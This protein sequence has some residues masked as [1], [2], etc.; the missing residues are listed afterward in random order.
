MSSG[1]VVSVNV[2]RRVPRRRPDVPSTAI[3]KQP[4]GRIDVRDPGPK[5]GGLGSGAVGDEIGDP[6]HHGGRLQAVY[7]YAVEDQRWWAMQLGRPIAPGG[8]GENLTLEG[9]EM[10]RALVGEL[11]TVGGAVLRVEVPRIPCGTFAEHMDV[12]Q[13]VR[14]FTDEGRTGAYLSVVTPGTIEADAPVHVEQPDHDI[15]LLVLVRA[16]TGDLD[17]MRRVIDARVIDA[18]V[19]TDLEHTLARRGG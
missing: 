1:R 16:F 10:T 9:V 6:R 7:A 3:D 15:D 13:W 18:E 4:V 5:R 17:A 8:F 14:R 11:W 12:P 19:Q 2:G